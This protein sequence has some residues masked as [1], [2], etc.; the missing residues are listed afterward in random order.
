MRIL[1]VEDEYLIADAIKASLERQAHHVDWVKDGRS[2][3]DAL[4]ADR[5]D[6][7]VLDLGLPH[8]DG[9]D[10]LRDL[11]RSGDK[12]PVLIL[13]ARDAVQNRI[14]G[15]DLGADDYLAK[16]FDMDELV[17]RCRALIRR[18]NQNADPVLKHGDVELDTASQSVRYKSQ[19]IELPPL[20]Y[21]TLQVL[22]ERQGRVVSKNDLSAT[23][24]GWEPEAESNVIEVYISQIRKKTRNDLIRTIRG[25]GYIID[26][27]TV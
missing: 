15:L 3:Q 24:Y 19:K 27:E 7:T 25:V 17:A 11:R 1:L 2:A 12:T 22:L 20:A 16:P 21:Q 18:S 10:V 26:T 9:M 14:E 4:A 8:K 13:T 5:F 6:L 23:L